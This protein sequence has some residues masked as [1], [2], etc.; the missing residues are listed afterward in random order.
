MLGRAGHEVLTR[1]S[2]YRG[3]C[4]R[5]S[6][7]AAA[8]MIEMGMVVMVET[9]IAVMMAVMVLMVVLSQGSPETQ[10]Q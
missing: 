8:T 4:R 2:S 7:R 6:I 10:N 3:W 5:D 1:S 9:M